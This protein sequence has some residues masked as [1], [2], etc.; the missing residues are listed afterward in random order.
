MNAQTVRKENVGSRIENAERLDP[1]GS[2][3]GRSEPIQSRP[4]QLWLL[5]ILW[6]KYARRL[7]LL[8]F[9]LVFVVATWFYWAFPGSSNAMWNHFSVTSFSESKNLNKCISYW[10]SYMELLEHDEQTSGYSFKSA[11]ENP[12]LTDFELGKLH[13]HRGEFDQA[14]Q[15]I[16]LSISEQGETQQKLFWLA[17]SYFRNAETKNCLARIKSGESR[18][19]GTDVQV[20]TLPIEGRCCHCET[21]DT[22]K[23]RDIF[24]RLLNEHSNN[25]AIYKWYLNFCTLALGQPV[26][27]LPPEYQISKVFEN[28]FY[29]HE[30]TRSKFS[31]LQFA[32]Q[33]MELGVD[34]LDCGRGVAVEDFDND[35]YLDIVTGGSFQ[36]VRFYR[37]ENGKAFRDSTEQVGLGSVTQPFCISAADFNNDGWVDLFVARP[38]DRFRLFQNSGDGK[39]EDVTESSG[40][41]SG[42]EEDEIAATWISAWAD[43]DNDGDLDLFLAQWGMKLPFVKGIMARKRM[44]STLFRNDGEVDGC[45][46]FTDVTED[47]GLTE[48]VQDNY[49]IGATFGDYDN[50]GFQDLFLSSPLRKTS[51]LFSNLNGKKF[52]RTNLI[53]RPEGGFSA[54]FVDINHDGLLD[55]FQAGFGD[56][57]SCIEQ[58][59]FGIG[60]ENYL[61]GHSAIFLQN[62]DGGFDEVPGFFDEDMPF[63]TMG[64]NF[65]D[66]DND[67]E[68]DFYLGTGTPEPWSVMPN[69]MFL[70]NKNGVAATNIS[71]IEGFGT[72]QKGHGVVFFDFDDDGDQ[73]V[74]SSLGGMW[75]GDAWPNQFHVNKSE[76]T[77][78]WIKIRLVGSASNRFGIGAKI[79]V[80]GVDQ[81]KNRTVRRYLITNQTG[82]GSSPYLAHMGMGDC[83]SIEAVEVLWPATGKVKTY[84]CS[85]FETNILH[86]DMPSTNVTK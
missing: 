66:L 5:R 48:T 78:S 13:Y 63:S 71:M 58:G 44:P 60:K 49:F 47:F 19:L 25:D 7:Y 38:F 79:K 35:G 12:E 81:N 29:R 17:Q 72:V 62:E 23:A 75:P 30:E 45:T 26:D 18:N 8:M 76:L 3:L 14:I 2:D 28:A 32:D 50:D 83:K 9:F 43:I 73:D 24:L 61:A 64:A 77:N 57:T 55:V 65:G 54:S 15:K 53:N 4:K 31:H 37:N 42:L 40:M 56:A 69:L 39:F 82:F 85:L 67:G 6:S 68:W 59:M 27:S 16:E 34:T 33:A 86:E 41:L 52:V 10:L 11:F 46:K 1:T 70:G 84:S 51:V 74:Y 21:S 20:C 80:V 36:D 22:I